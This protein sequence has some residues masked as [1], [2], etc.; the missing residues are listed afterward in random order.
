MPHSTIGRLLIGLALMSVSP[1]LSAAVLR[2]PNDFASIQQAADAATAGDEIRVGPGTYC[3]ATLEKRLVLRGAGNPVIVG[4][5]TGPAFTT[6]ARLGFFL[7]GSA[8]TSAA[9]GS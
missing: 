6:G 5:E 3:G 2:V 8:G 4:C 7:P 9:S 1:A